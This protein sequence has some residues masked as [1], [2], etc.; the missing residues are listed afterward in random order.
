MRHCAIMS[1]R[2]SDIDST[3]KQYF[4]ALYAMID[5]EKEVND[6]YQKNK[7]L[8]QRARFDRFHTTNERQ[9]TT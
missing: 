8:E 4:S 9:P 6:E 3:D 1:R 5:A 2:K 7:E